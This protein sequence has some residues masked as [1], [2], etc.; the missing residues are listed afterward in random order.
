MK[1]PLIVPLDSGSIGHFVRDFDI[2]ESYREEVLGPDSCRIYYVPR[3]W[4]CNQYFLSLIGR[5]KSTL[6]HFPF[7]LAHKVMHKAFK[8]YARSCDLFMSKHISRLSSWHSKPQII[9]P[10]ESDVRSIYKL[11][12]TYLD[13]E[14]PIITLV[15]RDSGYDHFYRNRTGDNE[16][17][18]RQAYRNTPIESFIPVIRFFT[19][20]GYSV[21]RTGRHSN[22]SLTSNEPN[23]LD[24]SVNESL[25]SDMA[26]VLIPYISE[27]GLSTGSGVDEF[28]NFFRK[29]IIR[30]NVSPAGTIPISPISCHN[31]LPDYLDLI[32]GKKLPLSRVLREPLFSTPPYQLLESNK[33][34]VVP[35]SPE[36]ML[37]F[38]K[39]TT[40][41][42]DSGT[43]KRYPKYFQRI[44]PYFY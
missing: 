6:P 21:V 25:H 34:K 17:L 7:F 37:E 31:L 12:G 10:K 13:L 16:I 24:Y 28:L 29:P 35:K 14:R 27:F 41:T 11:L 22:T 23:F 38:A 2:M 36:L 32:S 18:D 43:T 1:I 30:F 8:S 9:I 20:R 5:H 44:G 19:S 4:V 39:L 26:D 40:L 15:V 33:I 42:R 3:S